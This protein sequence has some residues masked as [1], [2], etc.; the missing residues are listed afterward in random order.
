MIVSTW[1]KW[2][3]IRMSGGRDGVPGL[4]G[5]KRRVWT[6]DEKRRI[7]DESFADGVSI[8]EVARLRIPI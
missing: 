5:R 2:T 8:A 6:Q 1:N 3:L 4:A 7:V